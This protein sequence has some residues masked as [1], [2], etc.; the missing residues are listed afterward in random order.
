MYELCFV[1]EK[2]IDGLY[3]ASLPERHPAIERH[4]PVLHAVI[5]YRIRKVMSQIHTDATEVTV[6]EVTVSTEMEEQQKWS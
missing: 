2:V 5:G 1:L 3:Y 4:E 6:P